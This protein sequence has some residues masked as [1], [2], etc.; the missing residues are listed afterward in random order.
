AAPGDNHWRILC[1]LIGAPELGRDPRYATNPDR[2]RNAVEVRRILSEW[3]SARTRR[4]IQQVL[5]SSVSCGVVN[6]VRDIMEDPHV[7][8]REMI[9]TVEH[10]GLARPVAIA[11][12]PIKMTRTPSGIRRRAPILG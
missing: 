5:A 6:S 1:E 12:T 2:V 9:A 11:G 8:A 4:E 10:P 7:K 3:T